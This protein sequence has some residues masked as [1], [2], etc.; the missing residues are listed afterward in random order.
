[1]HQMIST[2]LAIK[3]Q[4]FKLEIEV[5]IMA[6]RTIFG[7]HRIKLNFQQINTPVNIQI[8]LEYKHLDL[9][10][11]TILKEKIDD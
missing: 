11:M 5:H 8:I 7:K 10:G 3:F 9:D 2:I 1:M 6:V 4:Q